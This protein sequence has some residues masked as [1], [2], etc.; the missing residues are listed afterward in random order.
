MTLV[1]LDRERS[2]DWGIQKPHRLHRN[3]FG[4]KPDFPVVEGYQKPHDMQAPA[5]AINL[6][7][8]A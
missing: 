6:A 3:H 2:V 7:W 5:P 8:L 4:F 1:S